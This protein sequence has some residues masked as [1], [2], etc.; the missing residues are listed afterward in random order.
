[1]DVPCSVL[2]LGHPDRWIEHGDQSELLASIGLDTDGI[3][4]AIHH[5]L[6]KKEM[7]A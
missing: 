4:Q 5:R 3:I 6:G 2:Q 1:M 7:A